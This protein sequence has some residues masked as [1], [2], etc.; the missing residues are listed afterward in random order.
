MKSSARSK[1]P[2][3]AS[4]VDRALR[5]AM[6]A[7]P[8]T[9]EFSRA[10]ARRSARSTRESTRVWLTILFLLAANQLASAYPSGP[11]ESIPGTVAE[12]RREVGF[13]QKLGATVPM[14]AAFLDENG[15]PTTLRQL[16]AS[17]R[18]AILLLGYHECPMLCSAVLNAVVETMND[19]RWSAGREFDLI[20][21]DID[22]REPNSL[23]AAKR[24]T[25]LKRYGR[26]ATAAAGWHFLTTTEP[27]NDAAVRQLAES[28]GFRYRYDPA[29]KQYAHA[30]G[31]VVLTPEGRT[32]RYF[33]GI[34]FKP[35]ELHDALAAA[36]AHEV[37]RSPIE[38]IL[39]LCFHYN[40]IQGKYG[41]LILN[42]LR[43]GAVA[44]LLALGGGVYWLTRQR[45]PAAT[46]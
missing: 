40:P 15:R 32:S 21:V 9:P 1:L 26:S 38:Q 18:P 23:A 45:A 39:L 28:I 10:A 29:T 12:L 16:L 31:F 27:G 43:G 5:R 11:P 34:N 6:S 46:S 17:G 25:Y 8:Q 33:F 42:A 30:S 20:D 3:N 24:R 41:A 22:P 14:D 19:L 35:Q 37:S 36:G 13:D 4:R 44:T 7:V 2:A